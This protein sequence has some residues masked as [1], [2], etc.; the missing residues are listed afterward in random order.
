M[1]GFD[2]AW[3]DLREPADVA[4]R[5]ATV[6]DA[7]VAHLAGRDTVAVADLACG[8]GAMLRALAPRLGP[9]QRWT[10]IDHDDALLTHARRRLSRWADASEPLGDGLQ[11]SK[12]GATIDVAFH[13]ADLSRDPLPAPAA[14]ADIVTATA[15]FD[16]VG[17]GWLA[18]FTARLASARKP[19]YATLSYDGRQSVSPPDPLDGAVVAAFNRHQRTDKGFGPALGPDAAGAL[20]DALKAA[21][22][23]CVEGDSPWRLDAADAPLVRALVAGAADAAARAPEPEIKAPAWAARRLAGTVALEIGHRDLFAAP[24]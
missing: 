19:L 14:H 8:S 5:S 3:L 15:L 1:S 12:A 6:M 17:A 22:Y 21:G 9:R 4:A 18:D 24:A 16:L 20:A 10:L 13:A 7:A 2:A 11:L 23:A